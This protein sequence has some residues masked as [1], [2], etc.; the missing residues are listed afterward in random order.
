MTFLD[1]FGANNT[2]IFTRLRHKRQMLLEKED[3]K[4]MNVKKNTK[5][6][7]SITENKIKVSG[8]RLHSSKMRITW[9]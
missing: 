7:Q 8:L 1:S 5:S 9:Y 6:S 2:N 3:K 4:Q